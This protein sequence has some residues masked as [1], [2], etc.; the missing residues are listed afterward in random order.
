MRPLYRRFSLFAAVLV[1]ALGAL[2]QPVVAQDPM[3]GGQ[4]SSSDDS[5]YQGTYYEQDRLNAGLRA[6]DMSEELRTPQAALEHFILAVRNEDYQNAAYALNM[7]LLTLQQQAAH[8]PEL[9][10]KLYYLLQQHALIDWDSL[11]DRPDGQ[12]DTASAQNKNPLLGVP[13]RNI[14][15]GS[16]TM[17]GRDVP[18]RIQRVKVGD[19][20]P[21]WVFSASTVENIPELYEQYHP[22]I[23]AEHAPAWTKV[24]IA[25]G[26]QLWEWGSLLIL[27][28]V[29][30]G[31]GALVWYLFTHAFRKSANFWWHGLTSN[32]ALPTATVIGLAL[33]Y[34][35]V[36]SLLSLTGPITRFIDYAVLLLLIVTATWL[37]MRAV[38]FI[39][40]YVIDQHVLN[41]TKRDL[42]H[43]RRLSTILFV[44][45]RVVLFV[46]FLAGMALLLN[47]LGVFSRLSMSLLASA[48]FFTIIFGIAAQRFLGD[49]VAGVQIALTQPVRVG[50]TIE[51]DNTWGT[52]ERITYTY[53]TI[54][55]WDERRVM[56][57]LQHFMS[58][59]VQNFTK[60]S[61]NLIKPIYLYVDYHTD[62]ERIRQAF[63]E[64]LNQDD[65]WDRTIDPLVHVT[66]V[67]DEAMEVRLLCSANHPDTAWYLRFRINEQMMAYL[68]DEEAGRYLPRQRLI[69]ERSRTESR[70]G[71]QH[72]H[73]PASTAREE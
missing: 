42:G 65:D 21:V 41:E 45:R 37:V 70:N 16:I 22:G 3:P 58:Q 59:P 61:A 10:R 18:I 53:L 8:A 31:T 34:I 67:T 55:T 60:T 46:A 56:V 13:R 35:A 25:G 27:I 30:G 38:K 68:R 2:P 48:G 32:I 44:G 72:Q 24:E 43:A 7:R 64:M 62:V 69:I 47:A 49:I 14:R 73:A 33:L 28:L 26:V 15:L 71:Q 1:L 5:V 50:D 12:L 52:V 39:T 11:P 19:Q 23:L 4:D 51:F 36:R 20:Q 57:P 40:D 17:N 54:Y 66:N 6:R 29:S 9:A 63:A